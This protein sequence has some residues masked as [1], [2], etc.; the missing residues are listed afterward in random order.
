MKNVMLPI[1]LLNAVSL[2]TNVTSAPIRVAWLDNI[3]IQINLTGA[4]EGSFSVQVSNDVTWNPD[5]SLKGAGN[6]TTL[7]APAA[8][9][10]TGG[11]PSPI[12]IDVNQTGFY[13][14]RLVWTNNASPASSASAYLM[15]KG[16]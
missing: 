2:T 11:A 5:G 10:V 12:A 13:G 16:V 6:W 14:I 15:A 8:V 4:A 9:A 7:T 1:Q 3:S